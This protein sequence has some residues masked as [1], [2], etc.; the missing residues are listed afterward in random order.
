[1]AERIEGVEISHPERVIFADTGLTKA[2]LARYYQSIAEPMLEES[3]NRPLSLLRLPDGMAGERFFQKHPGKG[4]P[5]SIR[6]MQIT[7]SDG[8]DAA[9]AYVTDAAGLVA[10]AQMGTVEFHI[11]PARRDRLERPDRLVL[12]LDPDEGLGFDAVRSAALSLRDRLL[13]L[14]LSPWAMLSGGK[15]VHLVVT[16]R[17]NLGWDDLKHFARDFAA[18]CAQDEPDRYTV[19]LSKASRK[20]RIFID[21][22]RNERGSTAIAPFSVRARPGAPV[23]APVGWDELAGID[24]ARAFGIQAAQERGWAGVA[25]KPQS[26]TR[27][28]FEALEAAL[29]G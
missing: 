29:A 1:M 27:A 22:L 15:G 14:G 12:D 25:R 8:E 5:K 24:T 19:E 10:A 21:W 17:R 16:L 3:A 28:M 7:E 6:Q 11:W 26:L 4:F 23:A 9:Y 13:D 20:G 18:L 2:G